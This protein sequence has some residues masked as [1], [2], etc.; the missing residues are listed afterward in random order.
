MALHA[1]T[2]RAM[3]K[4]AV[5]C[6]ELIIINLAADALHWG[7]RHPRPGNPPISGSLQKKREYSTTSM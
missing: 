1:G 3:Q 2:L 5:S 6:V 4:I 7:A